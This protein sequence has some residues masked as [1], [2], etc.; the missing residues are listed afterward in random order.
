MVGTQSSSKTHSGNK[1]Q[2]INELS[3]VLSPHPF[4]HLLFLVVCLLQTMAALRWGLYIGMMDE[5]I[6]LTQGPI[7]SV[8]VPMSARHSSAPMVIRTNDNK[9]R[10]EVSWWCHNCKTPGAE[11]GWDEE[12]EQWCRRGLENWYISCDSAGANYKAS[13]MQVSTGEC[14]FLCLHCTGKIMTLLMEKDLK[15][16]PLRRFRG[17]RHHSAALLPPSVFPLSA[18]TH[19]NCP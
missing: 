13:A 18:V 7:S 17:T 6:C 9:Q 8:P 4:L 5:G 16:S 11:R 15:V 2:R 19:G 12:K 14:M 3:T 10:R 1:A